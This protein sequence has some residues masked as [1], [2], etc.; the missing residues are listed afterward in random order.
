L[1]VDIYNIGDVEWFSKEARLMCDGRVIGR[2][3]HDSGFEYAARPGEARYN[4][5]SRF[6]DPKA[7]ERYIDWATD[8]PPENWAI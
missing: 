6:N 8:L 1:V 3:D 7:P 4:V 5:I 2:I